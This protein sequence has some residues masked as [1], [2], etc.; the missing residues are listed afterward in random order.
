MSGHCE[1]RLEVTFNNGI[2]EIHRYLSLIDAEERL[3]RIRLGN[4]GRYEKIIVKTLY[5]PEP[6]VL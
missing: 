1:G 4:Q 2:T 6:I 3:E 5:Y